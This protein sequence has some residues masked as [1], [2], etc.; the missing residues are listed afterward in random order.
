MNTQ[1]RN[2]SFVL[3]VLV[4]FSALCSPA[5]GQTRISD[6]DLERLLQNLKEDAKS[7]RPVFES[8]L[9]QSSI[10]RTSQEKDAR[11][12]ADRFSKET[13]GAWKQFKKT[14]NNNVG[15]SDVSATAQQ[16]DKLVNGL[17][18][19]GSASTAWAK[20]QQELGQVEVAFGLQKSTLQPASSTS[21]VGG[22]SCRL[23]VGDERAN[24]LVEECSQVST[25]THTPYNAENSC[26]LIIDEIKRSCALLGRSAPQYCL[27][28]K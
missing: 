14:R 22:S 4:V 11:Q 17:G 8:S 3:F 23:A 18:L 6:N 7:F 12:L 28:Y 27:E 19:N 10:R 21:A 25:A 2:I 20:I 15:I 1:F 9:K 24:R 26:I 13:E 16:I 5:S